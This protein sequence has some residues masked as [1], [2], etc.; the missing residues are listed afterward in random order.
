MKNI[1]VEKGEAQETE[2]VVSKE[3][4]EAKLQTEQAL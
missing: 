3:E 4:E 1:E 2:K